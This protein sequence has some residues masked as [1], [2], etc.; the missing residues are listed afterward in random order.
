MDTVLSSYM[1]D[2]KN[3]KVLMAPKAQHPLFK[4]VQYK[5]LYLTI[6]NNYNILFNDIDKGV[7][8]LN[9]NIEYNMKL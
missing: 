8:I 9:K 4:A 1:I 7:L 5:S 3:T 2:A 6:I